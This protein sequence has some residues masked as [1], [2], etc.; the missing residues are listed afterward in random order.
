M[1]FCIPNPVPG[2]SCETKEEKYR[3]IYE[4]KGSTPLED[5]C[6]EIPK[7]FIAYLKYCRSLGMF[8]LLWECVNNRCFEGYEEVPN[9]KSLKLLFQDLWVSRGYDKEEKAFDWEVLQ[10]K[11]KLLETPESSGNQKQRKRNVKEVSVFL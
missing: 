8:V 10:V 5:L 9:Y 2:L 7:E 11:A 4:C 6:V 1:L 3:K